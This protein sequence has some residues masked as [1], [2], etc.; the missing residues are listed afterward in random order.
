MNGRWTVRERGAAT[1]GRPWLVL[2][3][4]GREAV[5]WGGPVLELNKRAVRLKNDLKSRPSARLRPTDANLRPDRP[6]CDA[7]LD[8]EARSRQSGISG[9]Q[10]PVA[11]GGVARAEARRDV[12]TRSSGRCWR[13]AGPCLTAP[14][15]VDFGREALPGTASEGRLSLPAVPAPAITARGQG[16][17]NRCRTR[18]RPARR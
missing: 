15:L 1:R 16:D 4:T 9:R 13:R 17:A 6:T 7:L 5:L 18:V 3:G 11:S 8:P 10:R 14:A 12:A 2:R